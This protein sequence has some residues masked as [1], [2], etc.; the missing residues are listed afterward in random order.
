MLHITVMP[1]YM[2]NNENCVY[3]VFTCGQEQIG[4]WKPKTNLI[5]WDIRIVGDTCF[6]FSPISSIIIL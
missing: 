6:C 2:V 1:C 5:S 3:A 4:T